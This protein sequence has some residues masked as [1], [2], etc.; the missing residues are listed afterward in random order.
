[1]T[2]QT[3]FAR[4]PGKLGIR[5]P[6]SAWKAAGHSASAAMRQK[7]TL[8]S[9]GK[10]S[11][12]VADDLRQVDDE[13]VCF[14]P[15]FEGLSLEELLV[16]KLDQTV[17]I[18][19]LASVARAL[20]RLDLVSGI[21]ADTKSTGIPTG[22][23][24]AGILVS[25][26][27]D[28]LILPPALVSR[29]AA[30]TQSGEGPSPEGNPA[31]GASIML[32]GI[33]RRIYLAE[34]SATTG[35]TGANADKKSSPK[36]TTDDRRKGDPFVPLGLIAPRL[37]PRLADL[38]DRAMDQSTSSPSLA[39]WAK[40]L[41]EAG[42]NKYQREL[43]PEQVAS[44]ELQ[45]KSTETKVAKKLAFKRFITKR[46]SLITGLAITA[47]VIAAIAIF[48]R[49]PPGP[50][51]SESGPEALVR[52][53]YEAI[54]IMDLATMD[55]CLE[56]KAGKDDKSLVTNLTVVMKMRQAYSPDALFISAKEWIASG[57]PELVQG[58][59]MFGITDLEIHS[60]DLPPP[61]QST[62]GKTAGGKAIPV[63]ESRFE[64]RYTLWTTESNEE[65]VHGA[66]ARRI[67][68]LIL[69]EGKNGWKITAIERENS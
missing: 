27:G 38:A 16:S 68:R 17:Q 65:L 14:G 36:A 64:A 57:S 44:L 35:T 15:G 50:D 8:V 19:R 12:W 66:P 62:D 46:G 7:G 48:D 45:L 1:M 43:S 40:A 58:A 49:P 42:K 47:V 21:P 28:V 22:I 37:D 59:L 56:G 18:Q 63:A 20:N 60:L 53:Y 6:R 26:N 61:R 3:I 13:V 33:L 24:S 9:Q 69:E 34:V 25:A 30:R 23:Q 55:A 51:L 54:D 67:D 10:L 11:D 52:A 41:D 2:E 32:A 29:A 5:I 4:E 39:D 31:I